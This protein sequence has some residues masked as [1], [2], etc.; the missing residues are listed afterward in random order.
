[1]QFAGVNIQQDAVYGMNRNPDVHLLFSWLEHE[2]TGIAYSH[3]DILV[4]ATE[5][6]GNNL[7]IIWIPSKVAFQEPLSKADMYRHTEEQQMFA[8]GLELER[9]RQLKCIAQQAPA[10]AE[11]TQ[12]P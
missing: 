8:E 2:E 10:P 5:D 4:P 3:F 7:D 1:M 6:D 12:K 11:A 9:E